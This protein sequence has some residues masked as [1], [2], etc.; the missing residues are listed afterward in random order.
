MAISLSAFLGSTPLILDHFAILPLSAIFLNLLL[1]PL[2]TL[3]LAFGFLSLFFGLL[4]LDSFSAVL[5]HGAWPVIDLVRICVDAGV[6]VPFS[7]FRLTYGP[8]WAGPVFLVGLIACALWAS[9]QPLFRYRHILPPVLLLL[10][11]LL[12]AH[13]PD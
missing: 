12:L 13:H 7:H 11:S 8:D 5:N 9:A 3:I 1:L 4:G 6:R 10:V 2:A